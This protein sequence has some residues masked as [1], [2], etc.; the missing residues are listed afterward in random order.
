MCAAIL[1]V[2]IVEKFEEGA[3]VTLA[4]TLAL[5]ALCVLIRRHYRAVVAKLATLTTDLSAIPPANTP[6]ALTPW[7]DNKPTAV[8]LVGSYGGVG[9]HS[10]LS[11]PRLFP[12]HFQQVVYVS[13]AVV[14]SGNFKGTM[15]VDN[16][17]KQVQ[18]SLARYVDTA[19]GLGLNARHAMAAGHEPVAAAEELCQ[20]LARRYPRAVFFAGKLIFEREHW[21]QRLLHNETAYAIQRR[22]Q[23]DGL[24]MVV[25]PIRVQAG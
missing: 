14:D 15:E 23:W 3:W 12:R 18:A 5:I 25:L 20:E 7:D 6:A 10:L 13:I 17:E 21:Y 9:L 19:R 8:L 1:V 16:L 24:P 22:L 4:V 11:I 2:V